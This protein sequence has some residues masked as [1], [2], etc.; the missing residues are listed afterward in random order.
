MTSIPLA[1]TYDDV[2]IRPR[3]TTMLSRSEANTKTRLTK[4]ITLN[5]PI[6]TANMDTVTESEMAIAVARLGGI[7]VIHRFMTVAE[8]AEEIRR[9]KRAKNFI[10]KILT[11]LIR[12]EPLKRPR[13]L[14]RK[15]ESA[16]F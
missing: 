13:S 9:V 15:K 3:R 4:K 16:D 5:V 10:K 14:A 2:L 6:V 1:L 8:N 12:S 7:G 11:L